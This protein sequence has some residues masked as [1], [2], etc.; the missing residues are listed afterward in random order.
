MRS[1]SHRTHQHLVRESRPLQNVIPDQYYG[2]LI[3]PRKLLER[4]YN[5]IPTSSESGDITLN[6]D[7]LRWLK[8]FATGTGDGKRQGVGS[9]ECSSSERNTRIFLEHSNQVR[10][11]NRQSVGQP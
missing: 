11:G 3:L 4:T 5:G 9:N 2:K 6:P 1:N 10:V 7:D 8:W